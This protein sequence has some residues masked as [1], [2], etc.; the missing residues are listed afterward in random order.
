MTG[1]GDIHR[2]AEKSDAAELVD[3][4]LYEECDIACLIVC[5]KMY[6]FAQGEVSPK[7]V[8]AH[9]CGYVQTVLSGEEW[10]DVM[11]DIDVHGGITYGVDD[12]GWVGFDCAHAFDVCVDENGKPLPGGHNYTELGATSEYRKYWSLEDVRAEVEKLAR[13][14]REL[15]DER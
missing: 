14:V 15:E 13:I 3:L 12:A 1:G 11:Y 9:Y 5:R 10:T 8:P 2:K 6:A 4:W 7:P